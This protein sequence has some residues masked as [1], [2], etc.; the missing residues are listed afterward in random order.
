MP[1]ALTW[2]EETGVS[3]AK[4]MDEKQEPTIVGHQRGHVLRLP[5]EILVSQLSFSSALLPIKPGSGRDVI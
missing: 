4:E 2:G 3:W 5:L 1:W